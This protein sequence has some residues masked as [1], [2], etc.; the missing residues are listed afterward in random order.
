M[1]SGYQNGPIEA[2]DL[3][4]RRVGAESRRGIAARRMTAQ[5]TAAPP[6]LRARR[7]ETKTLLA[8]RIQDE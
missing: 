5:R 1:G 7:A 4:A 2:G 3:Q 6:Y 8:R